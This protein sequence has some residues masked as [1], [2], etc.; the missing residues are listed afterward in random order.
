MTV[1][2]L[3]ELLEQRQIQIQAVQGDLVVRAARGSLDAGLA[4]SLRQKK[5]ELLVELHRRQQRAPASATARYRTIAAGPDIRITPDLL[6]LVSLSQEAI[7]AVVATVAGGAANVQD[8]YPLAPLQEGI[9]FHHLMEQAG[10]AYLLFNLLG[11]ASKARLERFLS[12]LQ[13]VIDR[14]DILRTGI[15]WEGLE[16]PVQVVRRQ[17]KL[18]V[19]LI[20]LDGAQGDIARQLEARYN[21]A[22]YRLDVRQAPLLRC[23]V[24]RDEANGRWILHVLAHHLVSDHRTLELILEEV[25]A[26]ER[27]QLERLP[28]PVPFRKFVAQARM[29]GSPHEQ[30]AFFKQMLGDIDEPTA[31]FGILD[32]RGNAREATEAR[33]MLAPELAGAIRRQ[34]RKLG[35]SAASLMHLAWALVLARTTG[36]QDVVFGTVLFGRMQAGAQANR[37][38]GMFINTLPVRIRVDEQGVGQSLKSIHALLVQ[39]LRYEHASLTVAQRSSAVPAQ[40]PLFTSLLNYR[41]TSQ[42]PGAGAIHPGEGIELLGGRESTHYPVSVDIDDLGPGFH[43]EGPNS[44]FLG[45]AA[46][47]RFHGQGCSASGASAGAGAGSV[48]QA[49]G[50]PV[51][52]GA[53]TVAASVE[54]GRAH[55]GGRGLHP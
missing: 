39:L 51:R 24:A 48:D 41:Y 14:H 25:W 21:P 9:L 38:L 49:T 5:G 30:A 55:G 7:D 35:V 26:I 4:E 29:R 43:G 54:Q 53:A 28:T 6:T 12:A 46:P 20:E 19:E 40:T 27:G 45:G 44:A 47:M 34:V 10:D 31:P 50:C 2:N 42:D 3:L 8:I 23:H 15:A 11:F 18:P 52:G 36:R 22:H 17:V 37:V 1:A 16:Q 13:R 33:Q 32:V